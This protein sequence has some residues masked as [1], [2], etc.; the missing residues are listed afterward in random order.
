MAPTPAWLPNPI[1]HLQDLDVTAVEFCLCTTSR[2]TG[3]S[4]GGTNYW[5]YNSLGLAPELHVATSITQDAV[6]QFKMMVR[7]M[8]AAG[9]KSF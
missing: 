6:Q 9:S 4:S 7:A 1:K 8:H 5:G 3:T 2:T